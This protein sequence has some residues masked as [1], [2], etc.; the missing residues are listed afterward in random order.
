MSDFISYCNIFTK[1]RVFNK[2]VK[3]F[4]RK[5]HLIIIIPP[6]KKKVMS[7][8]LSPV[9]CL[10]TKRERLTQAALNNT[11]TKLDLTKQFSILTNTKLPMQIYDNYSI[12]SNIFTIFMTFI[13]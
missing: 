3:Y 2:T 8:L 6:F 12:P 10:L 13:V 9:F 5:I 4:D 1:I 7:E 11:K